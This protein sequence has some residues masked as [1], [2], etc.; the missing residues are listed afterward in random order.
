MT[1]ILLFVVLP[2]VAVVLAIV[3]S[4]YR[5][6]A[7]RFS[8]SSLSSQFLENQRLFLGS[9]PWHY[10]ILA[11]LLAHLLAVLFPGLWASLL[12]APV[13][14]YVLEV[15]G[16][17]LAAA[18]LVALALLLVRRLGSSRLKVVTTPMDWVLLGGLL[19]QVGLG[20]GVAV[21]YRWGSAWYLD[22][23][24]PWLV[25]LAKLNPQVQQMAVLPLLVKLHALFA[26]AL[27]GILPFTR[28]VHMFTV[29]VAYLW[30]PFQVV[31]WNR[32]PPRPAPTAPVKSLVEPT[33]TTPVIV[34]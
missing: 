31:I 28:L 1:D 7:N 27:L 24:V 13:R 10:G 12:G 9:I 11:I 19:V 26:F 29:P 14:L 3:G 25:S 34:D 2:Y 17:A 16:M 8:Y 20:L 4:I 32:R 15:T 30:R 5:Y 22:T 18:A 23:A 33:S 6:F 21:F